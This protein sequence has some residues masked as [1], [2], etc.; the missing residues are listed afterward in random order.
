MKLKTI[1]EMRHRSSTTNILT[2]DSHTFMKLSS[3]SLE[4]SEAASVQGSMSASN[5]SLLAA[6]VISS[7]TYALSKSRII[8]SCILSINGRDPPSLV[9]TLEILGADGAR[10]AQENYSN[11]DS[12]IR[13]RSLVG[14]TGL[15]RMIRCSLRLVLLFAYLTQT[16]TS[17][18]LKPPQ[19]QQKLISITSWT[20]SLPLHKEVDH[21]LEERELLSRVDE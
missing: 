4:L 7:S 13:T 9:L 20:V 18:G 8:F 16:Q 1:D 10:N 12:L 2:G 19:L 11:G 17:G 6:A 14:L 3:G 5:D 15:S 21:K